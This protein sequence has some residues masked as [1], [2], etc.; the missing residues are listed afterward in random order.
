M[1]SMLRGNAAFS[2]KNITT[3]YLHQIEC[4]EFERCTNIIDVP[5]RSQEVISDPS[6]T[7]QDF[8]V[9]F[10][11]VLVC[12]RRPADLSLSL[13]TVVAA[14]VVAAVVPAVVVIPVVPVVVVPVVVVP[15]VI[16]PVVVVPVVPVVVV[17]VVVAVS[18]SPSTS[19]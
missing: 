13:A 11:A 5:C 7:K 1:E 14:V 12:A 9:S 16:V 17:P 19:P 4:L 10:L 2:W 18:T 3:Y 15:V 6:K 8:R